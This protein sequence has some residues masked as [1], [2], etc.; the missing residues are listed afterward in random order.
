MAS[1]TF[2]AVSLTGVPE[3]R[4]DVEDTDD[5]RLMLAWHQ[6]DLTVMMDSTFLNWLQGYLSSKKKK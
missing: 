5:G 4:R 3:V 1:T 6:S 2:V